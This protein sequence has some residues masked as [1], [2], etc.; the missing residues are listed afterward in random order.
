MAKHNQPKPE[1]AYI[2]R[3]WYGYLVDDASK[4]YEYRSRT[5]LR[6]SELLWRHKRRLEQIQSRGEADGNT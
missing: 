6:M 5:R 1:P 3:G 2:D 4:T